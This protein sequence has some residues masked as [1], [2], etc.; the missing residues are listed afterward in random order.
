[1]AG[2]PGSLKQSPGP[3]IPTVR[4]LARRTRRGA[5]HRARRSQAAAVAVSS[6]YRQTFITPGQGPTSGTV[7]VGIDVTTIYRTVD[8]LALIDLIVSGIVL[9]ALAIV[10]IAIVRTSLRPLTDIELTAGAIAARRPVPAGARPRPPDRG[11]AARPLAQRHAGPGRGRVPRPGEVRGRRPA[12][13]G[14]DAP[15]RRRRQPRAA[16]AADR[17]PRLRRVLPAARRR[18]QRRAPRRARER[19][20]HPGRRAAGSPSRT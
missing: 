18:G 5:G 20:T 15:V 1:M 7:L 10:G 11:R 13:R 17:D 2:R 16:D 6:S 19:R 8:A 4:R 9:V 12:V 3:A 14:K